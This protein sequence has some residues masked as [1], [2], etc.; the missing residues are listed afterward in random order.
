M[1][2]YEKLFFPGALKTP[3]KLKSR[4][5]CAA[6]N[7]EPPKELILSGYCVPVDNQGQTPWC[8]AYSAANYAENILWRKRGYHSEIDPE[9]LYRYAKSIDG[10]PHGDGTYLEC[11]LEAL[12]KYGHFDGTL[13]KIR[14]FGGP[15]FGRDAASALLDV[16]YAVHKYGI[17]MAGFNVSS[18]WF[19]PKNGVITGAT[20][21]SEGGHAVL[22]CGYDEG[23]VLVQNSWGKDYGHGGFVYVSNKAFADQFIYGAILTRSLDG[24]N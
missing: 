18:E 11:T 16:K 9:P 23:G 19:R 24:F 17:C 1:N 20:K 8:A 6:K 2:K 5:F 3:E 14:T 4:A 12:V 15:G 13:C 7:F 10:D 22:I 21:D